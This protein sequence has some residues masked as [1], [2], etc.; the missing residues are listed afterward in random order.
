MLLLSMASH[1]KALNKSQ[2]DFTKRNHFKNF[3]IIKKV[4]FITEN[5]D[6]IEC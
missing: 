3:L 5:L 4:R 6:N 2:A 1:Q